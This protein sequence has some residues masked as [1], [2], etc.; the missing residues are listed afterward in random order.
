[1]GVPL[2]LPVLRKYERHLSLH[3]QSQWHPSN[4]LE[5]TT[6]LLSMPPPAENA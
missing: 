4:Q 1:M 6:T 5:G 2:A 3:W